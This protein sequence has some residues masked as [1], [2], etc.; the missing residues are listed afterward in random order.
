MGATGQIAV[1]KK[2]TAVVDV[3]NNIAP[4]DL[5]KQKYILL[6]HNF[7][8]RNCNLGKNDIPAAS[9]RAI[10]ATSSVVRSLLCSRAFFHLSTAT[11][12]SSAPSA[13]ITNKPMKLRNGKL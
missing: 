2:A 13:K 3:V 7:T 10:P 12:I 5:T 8:E 6:I 9:G 1:A 11:N 4:E